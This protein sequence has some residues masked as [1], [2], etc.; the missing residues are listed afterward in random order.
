MST[1][2]FGYR[3]HDI[4][5]IPKQINI[6]CVA[7]FLLDFNFTGSSCDA[8]LPDP[9]LFTKVFQNGG[10][11]SGGLIIGRYFSVN[12]HVFKLLKFCSKV[13]SECGKY[14]FRDPNYIFVTK[15]SP[16]T[17]RT[18]KQVTLPRHFNRS[19]AA[20]EIRIWNVIWVNIRLSKPHC[21]YSKLHIQHNSKPHIA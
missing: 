18:Q 8:C 17:M 12:K 11:I 15:I 14:H 1:S 5:N 20:A 21:I 4:I 2:F 3:K 10:F 19:A 6:S 7:Q 16:Y 9:C 13:L